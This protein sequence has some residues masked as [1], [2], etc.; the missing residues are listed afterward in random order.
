M[1]NGAAGS[2]GAG[3][4]TGDARGAAGGIGQ[5]GCSAA[6]PSLRGAGREGAGPRDR[7][8]AGAPEAGGVGGGARAGGWPP[9]SPGEHGAG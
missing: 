2:G 7:S 1:R 9:G 8:P 3:T 5:R 4:L 6:E